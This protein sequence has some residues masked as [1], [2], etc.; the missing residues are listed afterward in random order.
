MGRTV[1]AQLIAKAQN[2]DST[3]FAEL[4][5]RYRAAAY[6]AAYIHLRDHSE[7]EDVTQ[8]ALLTAYE[9][10]GSLNHPEKFGTWTKPPQLGIFSSLLQGTEMSFALSISS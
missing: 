9:K 4:T 1:E 5:R 3:A 6:A 2:G 10:I 7:A 8:D